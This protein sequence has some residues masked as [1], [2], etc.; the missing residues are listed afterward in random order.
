MMILVKFNKKLLY[1]RNVIHHISLVIM[2]RLLKGLNYGLVIELTVLLK[3]FEL[4]KIQYKNSFLMI[5]LVM[6][7][8][9]GGSC[10]DLVRNSLNQLPL[11]LMFRYDLWVTL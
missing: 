6:E 3:F 7:Y 8:L 5:L 1:Y 11:S 4:V 2:A 10:L 9:A